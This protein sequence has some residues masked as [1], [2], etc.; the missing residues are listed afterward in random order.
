MND[1]RLNNPWQ[2]MTLREVVGLF[3]LP[4]KKPPDR[5]EKSDECIQSVKSCCS[6]MLII[7]Q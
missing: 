5:K 4:A 2:S 7:G 1:E 6:Y 3:V